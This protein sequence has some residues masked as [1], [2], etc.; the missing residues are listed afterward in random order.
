MAERRPTSDRLT[1]TGRISGVPSESNDRAPHLAH[2]VALRGT[3]YFL[4]LLGLYLVLIGTL[5]GL[6][7]AQAITVTVLGVIVCVAAGTITRADELKVSRDGVEA[8]MT[9]MLALDS[10]KMGLQVG[11]AQVVV[12]EPQPATSDAPT[13]LD[14]IQ[15]AVQA[16]WFIGQTMGSGH[17]TLTKVN[18]P[19]W[20]G[21]SAGDTLTVLVPT[22]RLMDAPPPDILDR[23]ASAGL[24]VA[25]PPMS[26]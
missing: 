21:G 2:Q 22:T 15:Y 1:L 17:L 3:P 25:R 13:L 7:E 20:P 24:K 14:V 5:G 12:S 23:L 8:K 9:P 26:G 11:A 4:A 19:E 18:M 16:G 10:R 6:S